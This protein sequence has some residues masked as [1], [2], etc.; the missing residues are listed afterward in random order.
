[1][2]E[3]RVVEIKVFGQTFSVK[4]DAEEAHIQAVAQYVN[5]KMEEILKKTRSVST[6]NVA[7]LTALN[8]A[9]DLLKEKEHRKA[10]LKEVEIKSKDL[11]EKINLRIVGKEEKK[12]PIVE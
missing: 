2:E 10:L 3:E 6:L 8:I 7:I 4:T 1:M 9:D 11:V 5:E 12:F